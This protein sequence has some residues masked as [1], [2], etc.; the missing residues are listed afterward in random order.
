MRFEAGESLAL[1]QRAKMH[2]VY[3]GGSE[4][5]EVVTQPEKLRGVLCRSRR[6]PYWLKSSPGA[7]AQL[8]GKVDH[9]QEA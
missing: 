1:L 5:V 4:G 8:W 2:L 7:A 6:E 9:D 3:F